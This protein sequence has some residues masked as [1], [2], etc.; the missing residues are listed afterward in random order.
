MRERTTT[1]YEDKNYSDVKEVTIGAVFESLIVLGEAIRSIQKHIVVHSGI[2][3]GV[4]PQEP[5]VEENTHKVGGVFEELER[6][7]TRLE[8]RTRDIAYELQ[9]IDA[10]LNSGAKFEGNTVYRVKDQEDGIHLD[11]I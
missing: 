10:V 3:C 1:H 7:I 11:R 8:C 9:R 6:E 5:G 4:R 2:L